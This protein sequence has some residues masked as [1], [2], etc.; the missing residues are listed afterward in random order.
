MTCK[1]ACPRRLSPPPGPR[2]KCRTPAR[3]PRRYFMRLERF[4]CINLPPVPKPVINSKQILSGRFM[5]RKYDTGHC[6]HCKKTFGYYLIHNGFNESSYAYCN[7]CGMTALLDGWKIPKGVQIP[8]HQNIS[9]KIE[10]LLQ[11]CK[12]GGTFKAGASPRCPHCREPL[13]ATEAASYI[14]AQAE[15]AKKGWRWQRSWTELYCIIIEE[16]IAHDVWKN[17]LV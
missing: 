1:P 9:A 10:P 14:E 13:S 12:C 8:R 6:E 4:A 11:P 5:A 15:G 3:A 7:S 16:K 17:L 2:Q